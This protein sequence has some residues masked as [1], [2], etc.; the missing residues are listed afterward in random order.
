MHFMILVPE[1]AQ[2]HLK[3]KHKHKRTNYTRSFIKFRV[4]LVIVLL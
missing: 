4:V 2:L 3:H 1:P